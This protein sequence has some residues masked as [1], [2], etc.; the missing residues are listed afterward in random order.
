MNQS[1]FFSKSDIDFLM[2][3]IKKEI[4]DE[5]NRKMKKRVSLARNINKLMDQKITFGQRLADNVA[6][7]GGSWGFIVFFF[8]FLIGWMSLNTFL[9]LEKSFDPYPYI[10]LNLF[11]S[12]LAAIQAPVIM[13]SQNRQ[14]MKD[15][16]QSEEDFETNT[17]S[18]VQIQELIAKID[19]F[20]D[21]FIKVNFAK[22][23]EQIFLLN[24]KLDKL[25]ENV[26]H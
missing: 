14:A 8:L 22:R 7:I 26:Q 4:E 6:R 18:E 1:S 3:Q 2:K 15:R 9:L 11:L 16:I 19:L 24:Q 23:E 10:L 20:L 12:C 17:R 21:L 25:I 5:F 13:M